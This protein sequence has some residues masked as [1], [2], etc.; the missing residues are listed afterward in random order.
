MTVIGQNGNYWQKYSLKYGKF[1]LIISATIL[2]QFLS[3]GEL[4][5]KMGQIRAY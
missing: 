2:S 5:K 1:V 4:Q 3:V